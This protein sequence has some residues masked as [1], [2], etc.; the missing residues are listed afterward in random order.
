MTYSI[1]GVCAAAVGFAFVIAGGVRAESWP[2]WRGPRGAG[3]AGG[4]GYPLTWSETGNVAWKTPLPGRG[5]SSPVVHGGQVWLTTA[6]EI[7]CTPEQEKERLKTNTSDQPLTLLAE[8]RMHAIALDAATGKILHDVELLREKDPQWVHRQNTY[9]SPTPVIEDGRLYAHFG[10][11]GTACVDTKTGKLLWTN[12]SVRLMHENG[13][14]SS[15]VLWRDKLIFHAD[16]SD[17]QRVVA[18]DKVTGKVAWQTNRTGKM[19]DNVQLK[20]S[21]ATPLVIERDKLPVL[22]SNGADW[23]YGYDPETGGEL[24][25]MA[26]GTQGFSLSAL[27]VEGNGLIYYS[28]GFM[29]PALHAV[30]CSLSRAPEVVWTCERNVPTIPSPL[31][32]GSELF[33]V[34]DS[35]ICTSLNATTGTENYRERLGG[36]FNASPVFAGGRIYVSNREGTTFVLAA[37]PAFKKLAE[38]KLPGQQWASI[39]AVDGSFFLRTDTALYRLQQK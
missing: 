24:W 31:L 35:N 30:R 17:T 29:K 12:T 33:F 37:G 16:G 38:N 8:V 21:Y 9:A 32:A 5:W 19:P 26:Y 2:Q 4:K 15:P 18:L 13:P 3:Q 14:G 11:F 27:P 34:A 39:A 1:S 25:K 10:T 22:L 28:T 6:L 23:L 36:D 7:P 20:K